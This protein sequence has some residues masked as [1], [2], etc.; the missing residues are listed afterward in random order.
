MHAPTRPVV[1]ETWWQRYQEERRQRVATLRGNRRRLDEIILF[2]GITILASITWHAYTWPRG[3]LLSH[4][5]GWV[6]RE[7]GER[8][9]AYCDACPFREVVGGREYCRAERGGVGCGC[10]QTPAWTWGTLTYK[11]RLRA[12]PCPRGPWLVACEAPT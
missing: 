5:L 8:R 6:S 12:W 11:R 7:T 4:R 2:E 3:F 1:P 9:R 10:P